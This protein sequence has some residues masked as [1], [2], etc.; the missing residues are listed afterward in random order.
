[1]WMIRTLVSK[2]LSILFPSY[3]YT[4]K[5]DGETICSSCL[6]SYKKPIDSPSLY[7]LSAFSYK[8]ERIK[9]IIH[10][11]KYFH[12]E[13]LIKPLVLELAN[14]IK[15]NP[16]YTNHPQ[17]AFTLVPIPMPTMRKSIRGYNQAEKIAI[18]LSKHSFFPI[19]NNILMRSHSPTRQVHSK[20]KS[21]RLLNQQNSF[22][23]LSDIT[24]MHIILVDDVTTTGATLNE[25]R[26]TLLK[27]GASTVHAVTLAH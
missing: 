1:M 27:A 11:I 12:R 15:G 7:I 25:A 22:K 19:N 6:Q 18:E 17:N 13:D 23:V 14:I 26:K 10:A 4:C 20:T 8:D 3:C 5:K 21:E 2:I 16:L 24:N 9:K